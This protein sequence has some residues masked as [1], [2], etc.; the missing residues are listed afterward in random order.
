M[1]IDNES[2][3]DEV[4]ALRD[5]RARLELDEPPA[6]RTRSQRAVKVTDLDEDIQQAGKKHA[7]MTRLFI[8]DM[9]LL[10]VAP[11]DIADDNARS[12]VQEYIDSLPEAARAMFHEDAVISLVSKC[13]LHVILSSSI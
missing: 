4:V 9:K 1:Q 3:R 7:V 13:D 10:K 12:I 6:K 5:A 2:L 8:V 11:E